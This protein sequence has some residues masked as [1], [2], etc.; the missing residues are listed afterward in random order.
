MSPP[1]S[2][3]QEYTTQQGNAHLFFLSR[4][5]GP[6]VGDQRNALTR[7]RI[8]VCISLAWTAPHQALSLTDKQCDDCALKAYPNNPAARKRSMPSF[9]DKAQG[10]SCCWGGN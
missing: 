2:N 5:S 9:T 1:I 8:L 6:V 7:N 4:A 10:V 3:T